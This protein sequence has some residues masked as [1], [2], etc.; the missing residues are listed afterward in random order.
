MRWVRK[1]IR[2]RCF[3]DFMTYSEDRKLSSDDR[4]LKSER[5]EDRYQ[6]LFLLNQLIQPV[7]QSTIRTRNPFDPPLHF[8]LIDFLFFAL[9]SMPHALFTRN[10]QPT[11]HPIKI[12][13]PKSY[14]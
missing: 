11:N 6:V 13:N 14:I 7:N 2:Y 9:C 8:P 3:K 1:R 10:P 5:L 4:R 12:F